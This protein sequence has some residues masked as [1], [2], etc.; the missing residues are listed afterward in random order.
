M[1]ELE[2]VRKLYKNIE[3][4]SKAILVIFVVAVIT[5]FILLLS[6]CGHNLQAKGLWFVTPY[7]SVGYGSMAV[8]KSNTTVIQNEDSS[9]DN[10][11]FSSKMTVG[12]QTTGYDVDAL[13][14]GAKAK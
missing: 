12:Q 10:F 2:Q 7:M 4:I 9:K 1:Q 6:G 3:K 8:V 11:K 14:A 13:K 5:F